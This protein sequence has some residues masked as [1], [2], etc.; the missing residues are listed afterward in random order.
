MEFMVLGWIMTWK[1]IASKN[2]LGQLGNS[3]YRL[4]Y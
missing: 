1:K 4:D 2:I 3:E